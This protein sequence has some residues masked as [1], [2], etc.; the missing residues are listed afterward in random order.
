[1]EERTLCAQNPFAM[2]DERFDKLKM[3]RAWSADWL[4]WFIAVKSAQ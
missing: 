3:E 4:D 2:A 1:M